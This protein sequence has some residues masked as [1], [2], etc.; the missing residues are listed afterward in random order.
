MFQRIIDNVP[1]TIERSLNRAVCGELQKFLVQKL[2]FGGPDAPERLQALISQDPEFVARRARL[3]AE[4]SKLKDIQ[5]ELRG[6]SVLNDVDRDA[7]AG[8]SDTS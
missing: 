2:N 1:L 3:E 5:N 7:K 8:N 4:I 6:L